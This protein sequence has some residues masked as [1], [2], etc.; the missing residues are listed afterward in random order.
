VPLS[1]LTAN[2]RVVARLVRLALASSLTE[3]KI[4]FIKF[5][6]K[7]INYSKIFDSLIILFK[8]AQYFKKILTDYF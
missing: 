8:K 7:N 2:L 6:I 1:R 5:M 4:N 3:K